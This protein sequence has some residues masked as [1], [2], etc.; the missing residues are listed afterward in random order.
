MTSVVWGSCATVL[1]VSALPGCWLLRP[2][3]G[4]AWHG[5]TS[6]MKLFLE[7]QLHEQLYR[8]AEAILVNRL[9]K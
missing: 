1:H 7:L 4:P 8:G 3:L 9:A 5:S 6:P 2:C